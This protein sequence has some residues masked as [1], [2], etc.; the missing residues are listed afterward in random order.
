MD[1]INVNYSQDQA[2]EA[3]AAAATAA[4]A[5]VSREENVPES[6]DGG[7]G[8]SS[9][10]GTSVTEPIVVDGSSVPVLSPEELA[11]VAL[12]EQVEK[13]IAETYARWDA[14]YAGRN[15]TLS[16]DDF[17]EIVQLKSAEHHHEVA[18]L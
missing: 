8:S 18:V 16:L 14:G 9:P 10:P 1:S 7:T 5:E 3:A 13:A 6:G 15:M 2:A 4:A 11:R 17:R 12:A